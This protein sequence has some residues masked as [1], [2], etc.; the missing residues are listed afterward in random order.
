MPFPSFW[1]HVNTLIFMVAAYI[2]CIKPFPDWGPCSVQSHVW[3]KEM[4]QQLIFSDVLALAI[5]WQ[6]GH[7]QQSSSIQKVIGT[8]RNLNR[9]RFR[10]L[11]RYESNCLQLQPCSHVFLYRTSSSCRVQ[12]RNKTSQLCTT[13]LTRCSFGQQVVHPFWREYFV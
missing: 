5:L 10:F 12:G 13:K 7:T 9:N 4:L 2:R 11:T 6:L 1:I 3:S 8:F